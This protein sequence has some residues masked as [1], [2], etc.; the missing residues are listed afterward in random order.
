LVPDSEFTSLRYARDSVAYL[1]S[2]VAEFTTG[3]AVNGLGTAGTLAPSQDPIHGVA[4][5]SADSIEPDMTI[6]VVRLDSA[7]RHLE[8]AILRLNKTCL[9]NA[10]H[11]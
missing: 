4:I 6:L 1:D 9:R 8:T 10:D 2:L 11:C 5:V 3:P 7:G